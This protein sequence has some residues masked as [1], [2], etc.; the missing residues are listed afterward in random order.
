MRNLL[1]A[2]LIAVEPGD[3][4]ADIDGGTGELLGAVLEANPECLGVLFD[5]P[6]ALEKVIAQLILAP[7][8]ERCSIVAGS[9]FEAPP[10]ADVYLLARVLHDWPDADALLIRSLAGRRGREQDC[11]HWN[12]PFLMRMGTTSPLLPI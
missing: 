9:L 7:L 2:P 12:W 3:A 4:V 11:T 5:R 10:S 1:C 6:H 8:A